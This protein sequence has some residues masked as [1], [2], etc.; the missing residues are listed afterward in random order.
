[1]N[2]LCIFVLGGFLSFLP[3]VSFASV[4]INEI[5]Y[6]VSGTDSGRE[7]VE[8][9]N[10]GSDSV[11]L[12]GWKFLE[13]VGASNH[14]LSVV[15]GSLTISANGFAVISNDTTKFLLDWPVFSGNL[16]KASFASF[17]NTSGTLL[18]KD[19]TGT[20][21]DQTTYD[22]S[23]GASGDGNSLQKSGLSWISAL[24]TP[25]VL[26]ATTPSTPV[27]DRDRKST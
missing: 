25:G 8:V 2:K 1:M 15:S 11:D 14:G 20:V 22:S 18:L 17:N 7:W 19:N 6:D 26:N 16:L 12:T 21:I 23:L 9:Y 24:P 27:S 13:S 5:M 10:S 3:N 4:I